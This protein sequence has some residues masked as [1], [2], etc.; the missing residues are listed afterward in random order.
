[1]DSP[2]LVRCGACGESP[3]KNAPEGTTLRR[4]R[5][6][7]CYDVWV[8]ARPVGIGA[9]CAGCDDKRRVHLRHYEVGFRSNTP[10]GRWLVLC[11]NCAAAADAMEPPPRSI[12][13]LKMRLHRERRWGDRR[14]ESVGRPSPRAAWLERR[15]GDRRAPPPM[16]LDEELLAGIVIEM[17]A[18]YE[19]ITDDQIESVEEVTGIHYRLTPEEAIADALEAALAA[20]LEP[21]KG[22]LLDE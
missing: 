2:S 20:G 10:G 9:V 19:E 6:R 17:E 11:H 3:A 12:D 4:G 8:R 21:P 22:P 5:C 7:R 18:D 15:Q 16:F 1:M 14:A 13:G